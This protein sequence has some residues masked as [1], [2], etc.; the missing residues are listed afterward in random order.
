MA[1]KEAEQQSS[2]AE[3][4]KKKLSIKMIAMILGLMVA[5]AAAVFVVL[6]MI[7]GPPEV[8]AE[9]IAE[10]PADELEQ[11]R[12]VLIVDDRFPNHQTGRVWLWET[13]VQMQVRQKNLDYVQRV[14]E[15]RSAEVKTGVARIVRTS[16]HKHLTE[17]N[18]D[19]LNRQIEQYLRDVFGFDAE[20]EP[21]VER[22]LIPKC[23]GF[24][25]D[26]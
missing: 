9:G 6:N 5:E 21:R 25:A 14:L 18:L 15:E 17:P 10:S 19:T 2:P 12:E 7:S 24:P 13:E 1:E 11:I 22:V 20:G 3:G 23:V 8:R 16:H 4:G 26:F